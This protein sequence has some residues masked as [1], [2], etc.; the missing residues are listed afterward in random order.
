MLVG[1]SLT[2]LALLPIAGRLPAYARLA[3]E[4]LADARVPAARKALLAGVVGYALSPLDLIPDRIPLLGVLDDVV[5]AVI[6]LELFLA[7][8]PEALLDEKLEAIG[9]PRAA[10]DEDR[11]RVRRSV[12]RPVRRI[13]KRLPATVD[14]AGRVTRELALGHRLRAWITKEGSPA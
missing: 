12:P 10:F 3:V 6:G 9:I 13:I 11:V 14:A 2:A 5:V 8:V 1:R 4:L 7:G